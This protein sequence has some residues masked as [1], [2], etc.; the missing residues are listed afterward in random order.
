[1]ARTAAEQPRTALIHDFLVSVRGADRVFLEMCDL[2]PDADVFTPVYDEHGTEGRFAGRNIHTSFLQRL[3]PNA[4]TFRAF[5]PLYPAAIESF[6]LSGYDLVIS[7]SSAWAHAVICDERAVHVSYCH[8][9]FRYAWNER[10]R[11][12]AERNPVSRAALSRL[13]RRWREWDWIA[14]QRVD[15]YVTN[16]R[17]T[18]ARIKAYFGRDSRI[19]Y[20]PVA[21]DRFVAQP[22]RSHYLVLSELVSH[23]QIDVAVDAFNR[24]RLPLVIA[25]GGPDGRRLKRL[26]GPTIRFAGRVSDDEAAR[27]LA[28]CQA[29]V[30]TTGEEFGIAAVEAQAAGR[31]VIARAAGGLLENVVD[32]VTG[33]LWEGGADELAEVVSEFDVDSVD[34][35]ACIQNARRFDASVFRNAFPRE[36]EAA[37]DDGPQAR[38]DTWPRIPRRPTPSR[39]PAWRAGRR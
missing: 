8:N 38:H 17:T 6:D 30:V 32:G 25:G 33:S 2:W 37:L 12:L 23:K 31:P 27:L 39:R 4:R 14:A 11:T 26:A 5:L 1:M 15:R 36:V 28:T 7:S 29:L 20:P 13:F 24:L 21:T 35:A 16:S 10:H 3:Q 18:Q 22:V 34:S 9:P 19:I